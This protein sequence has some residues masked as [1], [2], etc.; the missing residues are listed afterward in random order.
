[1][2]TSLLLI[3]PRQIGTKRRQFLDRLPVNDRYADFIA[4][5]LGLSSHDFGLVEEAS[6]DGVDVPEHIVRSWKIDIER[7]AICGHALGFYSK[8]ME[9]FAQRLNVLVTKFKSEPG[10]MMFA[11]SD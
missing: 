9:I 3:L 10:A 11:C 4:E 8:D 7:S 5:A 2:L 1:M 6:A